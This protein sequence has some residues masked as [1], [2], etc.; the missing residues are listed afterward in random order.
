[1]NVTDSR[2]GGAFALVPALL[3]GLILASQRHFGPTG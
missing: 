1:M 2:A 3:S